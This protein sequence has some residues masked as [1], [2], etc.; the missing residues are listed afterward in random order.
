MK[1]QK[2]I[3]RKTQNKSY[4]KWTITLPNNL[5]K[6]LGWKAGDEIGVNLK[7]EC[8]I[9]A[10]KRKLRED[11]GE[12]KLSFFERFTFVYSNLPLQERKMPVLV[13]DKQPIT[14]EM[15][16]RE[17]KEKTI[18]GKRIGGKLIKLGII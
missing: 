7:D 9:L 12:N 1:L 11:R 8:A 4:E 6:E 10:K 14:W 3:S 5:I 18:L 16:Y 15:A 17:I 13:I 2:Q